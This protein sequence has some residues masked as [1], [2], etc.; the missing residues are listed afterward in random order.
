[1]MEHDAY[2]L[3]VFTQWALGW[4]EAWAYGPRGLK[5]QSQSKGL[6]SW[7]ILLG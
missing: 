5:A 7:A 4:H 6:G 3:R 2:R 1:M